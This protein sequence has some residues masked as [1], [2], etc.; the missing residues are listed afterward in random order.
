MN[1]N[2]Q[3]RK[4]FP[5]EIFPTEIFFE[6]VKYTSLYDALNFAQLFPWIKIDDIKDF[7][8]KNAIF[9]LKKKLYSIGWTDSIFSCLN[10]AS[11]AML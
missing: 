4:I 3:L 5:N 10:L 1:S 6:I 9:N 7:F 2:K 8:L 11:Q